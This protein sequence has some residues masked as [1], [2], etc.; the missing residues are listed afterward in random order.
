VQAGKTAGMTALAITNT[1]NS[2]ALTQ[3]GADQVFQTYEDIG[4]F[5]EIK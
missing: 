3:A 5:F 4:R 2:E 1:F